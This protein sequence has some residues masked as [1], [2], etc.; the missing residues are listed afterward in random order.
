M[1]DQFKHVNID[2]MGGLNVVAA[3]ISHPWQPI[4]VFTCSLT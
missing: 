1:L 3:N 4:S 2:L